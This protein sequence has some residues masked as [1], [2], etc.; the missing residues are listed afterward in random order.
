MKIHPA[1]K[2]HMKAPLLREAVGSKVGEEVEVGVN[3]VKTTT[4]SSI[5]M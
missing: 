3:A 1:T 5:I 4:A 2:T